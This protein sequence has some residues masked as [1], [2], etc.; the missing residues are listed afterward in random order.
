MECT[1]QE[2]S[3]RV[4]SL[5]AAPVFEENGAFNGV[6]IVVTASIPLCVVLKKLISEPN[7]T[8]IAP[9]PVPIKANLNNFKESMH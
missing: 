8:I 9:I 1:T 2:G 7:A 5:N 3:V 6:V 4:L